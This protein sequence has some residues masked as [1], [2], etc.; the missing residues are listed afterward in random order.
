LN[1]Q[2]AWMKS[3]TH[4]NHINS[5]WW[6]LFMKHR[7]VNFEVQKSKWYFLKLKLFYENTYKFY[8]CV[9]KLEQSTTNLSF[10]FYLKHKILTLTKLDSSLENLLLKIFFSFLTWSKPWSNELDSSW[11]LDVIFE[12]RALKSTRASFK[13]WLRIFCWS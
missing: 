5:F 13:T 7:N 4:I 6:T 3:K 11:V 10:T 9:Y 12:V 2:C 8:V 1:R